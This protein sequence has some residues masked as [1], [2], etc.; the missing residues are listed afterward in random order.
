MSATNIAS[1]T[2]SKASSP[3]LIGWLTVI[4]VTASN[5]KATTRTPAFGRRTHHSR[6]TPR[7]RLGLKGW[8]ALGVS[9][10]AGMWSVGFAEDGVEGKGPALSRLSVTLQQKPGPS[11][12][13]MESLRGD[14]SVN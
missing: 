6:D 8:L 1:P 9:S 12:A 3:A 4:G 10:R 5:T 7:T 14:L 11:R 2:N 13:R